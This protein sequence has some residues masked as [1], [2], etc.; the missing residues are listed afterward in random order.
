LGRRPRGVQRPADPTCHPPTLGCRRRGS[1]V[2]RNGLTTNMLRSSSSKTAVRTRGQG[3][4]MHQQAANR[5]SAA[6][7]AQPPQPARSALLVACRLP[8]PNQGPALPCSCCLPPPS[9]G[10][11]LPPCKPN[12]TPVLA[13]SA[14]AA[15]DGTHLACCS[16]LQLMALTLPARPAL[17]LMTL[18]TS[19]RT[20]KQ[21][22][23]FEG[24]K[25]PRLVIHPHDKRHAPPPPPPTPPR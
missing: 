22:E 11:P 20:R 13:C 7:S 3:A 8:D 4:I 21:L 2:E 17:Q 25:L 5:V 6:C 19:Y 16:V 14:C 15:A 23:A 10:W 1:Y 18:T 24:V 9:L 12:P